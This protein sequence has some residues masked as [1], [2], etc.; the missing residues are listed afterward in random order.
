MEMLK[1]VFLTW[2]TGIKKRSTSIIGLMGCLQLMNFINYVFS[3]VLPF[4]LN[5]TMCQNLSY[6]T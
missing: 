1:T 5:C 6:C 2:S 4:Q 3:H